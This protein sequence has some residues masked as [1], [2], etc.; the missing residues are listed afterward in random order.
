MQLTF[1]IFSQVDKLPG[2]SS[3]A[4][5]PATVDEHDVVDLDSPDIAPY[6]KPAVTRP[7]L[8]GIPSDGSQDDKIQEA[9][10]E[11]WLTPGKQGQYWIVPANNSPGQTPSVQDWLTN[12]NHVASLLKVRPLSTP[13]VEAHVGN[14]VQRQA[15]QQPV[16]REWPLDKLDNIKLHPYQRILVAKLIVN[17]A[18]LIAASCGT[19]KTAVTIATLVA[20]PLERVLI[21]CPASLITNWI[22]ELTTFAPSIQVAAVKS[23][24]Q[25]SKVFLLQQ[26]TIVSYSLAKVAVEHLKTTKSRATI[27][28]LVCDETHYCKNSKSQRAKA[29]LKLRK[30][31]RRVALLTATPCSNHA[32]L[33]NLLRILDPVTFR[34][35]HHNQTKRAFSA[36]SVSKFYFAERYT[37]PEVVHVIGGREQLVF[38]RNR[39]A[40]ELRALCSRYITRV[41]KNHVLNLPDFVREKVVIHTLSKAKQKKLDASLAAAAVL[42]DTKGKLPANALLMQLLRDTVADK[43]PHV[44]RHLTM[45]METL[46]IKNEDDDEKSDGRHQNIIVFSHHRV[47]AEYL[48]AKLNDMGRKHILINGDTKKSLRDDLLNTFATC[49]DT[50]V[51]LLSLGVASTGLNLTMARHVLCAELTFSAGIHVQAESRTHRI[52]ATDTVTYQYLVVG[53]HGPKDLTTDD[54]V[55]GSLSRKATAERKILDGVSGDALATTSTAPDQSPPEGP[56]A[57]QLVASRGRVLQAEIEKKKKKKKKRKPKRKPKRKKP[58]GEK[59]EQASPKRLSVPKPEPV[60]QVALPAGLLDSVLASSE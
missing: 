35:F 55:Y 8:V 27:D 44:W 40:E 43:C 23:G 19:G 60:I 57:L 25:L 3:T 6:I 22:S 37:M 30:R 42:A 14:P 15:A 13:L 10:E 17:P 7:A 51:A 5:D 32:S 47:M 1:L 16:Q 56:S 34:Y 52:G 50:N 29:V 26:V 36:E 59:V 2:A 53:G 45:A 28:M 24:K 4:P 49:P 54:I 18:Q 58:E 20:L 9:L 12:I 31:S 46:A 21:V 33:Y 41:N 38:K 39:R 11:E 48:H